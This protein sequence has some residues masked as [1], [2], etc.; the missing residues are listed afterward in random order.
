M[1][2]TKLVME[3]PY[4]GQI[5]E[6]PVGFSWTV[7]FFA[8]FPPL[9]RRDWKWA[10]IMF[11]LTM[12]TMGLSGLLFMFIYNKLYIRDLIGDEYIVKSVGVG[13]LDQ[14]SQKLGINLPVR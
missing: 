5:K 3:S 12:I 1:A 6:A 2:Y 7:L 4:T 8:F 14:V 9:F 11:L 13:T 10:I